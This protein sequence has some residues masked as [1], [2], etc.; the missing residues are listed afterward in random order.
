MQ[1]FI[2][3]RLYYAI[4]SEV[5][6]VG[7]EVLLELADNIILLGEAGSGK[8]RLTDWLGQAEDY[9]CC[10]ARQ[11]INGVPHRIIGNAGTLVIDAIDEVAAKAEGDAVDLVLRALRDIEYPRF[12]LS[13]RSSEWRAATMREAIREQYGEAP[14]EVEIAPLTDNDARA[15][16]A[17]YLNDAD[18]AADVVWHFQ[19]RGLAEW[20]GN[21]QTLEMIGDIAREKT[22]PEKASEL[23]ASFVDIAWFEHSDRRPGAP[24]R[25][26]GKNVVLDALGAG[27]AALIL[28]GS[29]AL[30][31]A[32]RQKLEPGDLPRSELTTLPGGQHL[33]AALASRL[34]IG[35]A[36]Q[37]TFQ[38]KRIGEYIGAL[39]LAKRADTPSKRARL[40]AMLQSNG[41]IPSNLR[42]LHA[43]LATD[44]FLANEVIRADP[45]GV[46]E[47]GDAD[48]LPEG[49]GRVLLD[50]LGTLV[51]RNPLFNAGWNP[52]AGSLVK[53]KLLN[54]SW[55][56]LTERCEGGEGW[57]Y[58]FS[59][60][61]VIARQLG[62][63]QVVMQ[64]RDDLRAILL[65]LKQEFAIRAAAGK[66]LAV[67]GNLS[68]WPSLL[69]TLRLQGTESA[70]RLAVDLLADIG[71]EVISDRQ[72]VELV[73]ASEGLTLCPLPR[74]TDERRTVGTL[75]FIEHKLPDERID[76]LLG[77]LAA[78]LEHFANNPSMTVEAF[79]L[80]TLV[81][82][83]IHRRLALTEHRPLSDPVA[84][85]RWLRPFE[86]DRGYSRS[87][88][89]EVADWL[90]GHQS[91]RR[92]IQRYVLLELDSD[93]SLGWRQWQ[94]LEPLPGAA[95]D[96][97][98]LAALLD[99]LDVSDDRWRD[100][101]TMI[102]HDGPLGAEARAAAKR[103]V[104]NRPDML[105]WIDDL[106]TP[107]PHEWEVRNRERERKRKAKDAVRDA[108]HRAS[109]LANR[110]R[111]LTGDIGDQ[112]AQAY[113]GHFSDLP[114]DVPPY[115]RI[116]VWLGED[117]QADALNGFEAFLT[118]DPP[119]LSAAQIAESWADGRYWRLAWV[120]VAALMERMRL[121]RGFDDL[122]DERLI[123]AMLQIEHGLARS[124]EAKALGDALEAELKRRDAFEA[125]ARL[126][127]EPHLRERR[128]HITGLYDLM[129]E[130]AH[131]TL[132]TKFAIEW[133][134]KFPQ[135]TSDVEEELIDCLIRAHDK[136]TLRA[137]AAE[138]I[139]DEGR[140]E[141][142]RRNWQ[143][144]GLWTDFEK[145]KLS[146]GLAA[147]QDPGLLWAIR[148]RL[149]GLRQR[150]DAA[151]TL[152]VRLTAWI[153]RT[154]R[155]AWPYRNHPS[156]VRSGDQNAWDA[157]EYLIRLIG[158]LGDD[159]SDEAE[160]FIAELRDAP[161]DG[162]SDYLRR[163]AI[164]Q[165]AKRAELAYTPPTV[166]D[167]AAALD[168]VPPAT[169]PALLAE[170]LSALQRVQTR[171]RSDPTDSWRG[172]YCDDRFTPKG[173]EVCSDHL[174]NLL[175]LEA[176]EISF[177][178]EFHVGSNREVD[179]ACSVGNLRIPIEAKGQW[180]A[181]LW[182]AADWQLGGQQAVDHRAG[183]YGI[184]LVYWFGSQ[185]GSKGLRKQP[186][187][188][189]YPTSPEELRIALNQ[190][191]IAPDR[192]NLRVFVLDLSR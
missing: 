176:P 36:G 66:A 169:H 147:E 57:Q 35:P 154:F 76:G 99:S 128:A 188:V 182:T 12:I 164:E 61:V 136:E 92:A 9:T 177:T 84:L 190:V 43:W 103:F 81:G 106:A 27:F 45:A 88:R 171:V 80:K 26:L 119:P 173:E 6:D 55:R 107:K 115:E 127:I 134:G 162:Y 126:L 122:P 16:L 121:D 144:V 75:F 18:R 34:C 97:S 191:L 187:G 3:R 143:A 82:G 175:A 30:S 160:A 22:L 8:T 5:R 7:Q 17:N 74:V 151:V 31:N 174:A 25:D 47:Y 181:D 21:P 148:A 110:D 68:D 150:D 145:S 44:P 85:W 56:I 20:L 28:T 73:L 183:G 15:F 64:R 89:D 33:E 32:P 39:W 155:L 108:E 192:Q 152:P 87:K 77:E 125:Y 40:L 94:L 104:A 113:L 189:D 166:S 170:V 90:K 69:E 131:A 50:A 60:R 165:E 67:H 114:K 180:N 118:R 37:R 100:L 124:E 138:R 172:F 38:H 146:L 29:S 184:Y 1:A 24:L 137:T 62:D 140:D 105:H 158:Q 167:I 58:P 111:L 161:R 120:L 163:V 49:Q 91:E 112:P 142:S 86:G 129:R 53:G 96:S 10:T 65:D 116:G 95:L 133:L 102:R 156:G 23:F 42:G 141:R 109:Y 149:G 70:C 11:I 153:V 135:M 78:Y 83:L 46:I 179:I 19:Q 13:C 54:E 93:K 130:K 186:V 132:A 59:L 2:P 41:I 139:T 63:P 72:I 185:Q 178:P 168:G 48:D 157:S 71:F 52:R 101:L 4:G 123:S 117:L 79:D 159:A 14:V 98:D 51:E